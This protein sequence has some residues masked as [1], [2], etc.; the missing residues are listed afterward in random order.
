MGE[1]DYWGKGYGYKASKKIIEHGF[2]K[3][4]LHRCWTGTASTN[5]GMQ[6]LAVKLGFNAEGVFEDGM[7][8]NGSYEN[9]FVYG[10]I[11]G[12]KNN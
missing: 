2:G 9:I 8:L 5:I 12:T 6:K 3:L 7:F 1:P 10:M 4:N 11:N